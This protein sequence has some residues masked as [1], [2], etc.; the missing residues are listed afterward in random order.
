MPT[1]GVTKKDVVYLG[2][3]L[4]LGCGISANEYSCAQH[5]TYSPNKLWRSDSIFN[6]CANT[7]RLRPRCVVSTM[8][9]SGSRKLRFWNVTNKVR[10]GYLSVTNNVRQGY[11]YCMFSSCGEIKRILK[12][13][14]SHHFRIYLLINWNSSSN[15]S[16]FKRSDSRLWSREV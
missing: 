15:L 12:M 7:W 14:Y 1:Q 9:V 11:N 5:C 13:L 6:L 4:A 8:S 10:Q 16:R 2:W 3:P